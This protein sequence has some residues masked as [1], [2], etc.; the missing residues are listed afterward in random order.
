[1]CRSAFIALVAVT[2]PATAQ[3]PQKFEEFDKAIAG[4][5]V[6]E[7]LFKL[8]QKDEHVLAEIQ[9]SQLDRPFLCTMSL[10]RGG[11]DQAGHT[12]NGDEQWVIAFKR[13]GDKIHLVRKNV[14]F[15]AGGPLARAM[16]TTYTDSVL[17][18][19]RIKSV[20]P[21]KQSVLIDLNDVFFSNFA[22]LP[23]GLLDGN[24]TAWHKVK[25]FPKNVELQ[26]AATFANGPADD[27]VI[28][29]RG[30]TVNIHYGI[31]ELPETGYTPRH[32]DD[33]VGYFLTAL[34][35][36]GSDSKDTAFVRYVN[37][38][39]LERADNSTWKEGAKLVPPKKKIV[40][41]IEKSVPD[42]FRAAVRE[43]ILEW[44]KAFEKV[45][46]RDAIEVRQQ[47]G[48]DFDPEDVTYST[49]RWITTDIGYAMGPSRA[50]PFTGEIVDADIIFDASMVRYYRR[51]QQLY[52]TSEGVTAEPASPIQAAR[53]GWMIP[54]GAGRMA[55]SWNDKGD[56]PYAAQ[57]AQFRAFRAGLCQCASHKQTE[58]GL[59]LAAMATRYDLKPGDKLSDEMVQQAVKETVMHE[60]GHTLGLRHN[61]K[62]STMLKNEQ[63]HDLGVTRKQG[64]VGSVMDYN[65][66]N[67]APKGVK[68]GDYFTSTL[69]P[70]DYWAIEY[71]YKPLP[72]GTDGEREELGKIAAR[73][74][75]PGLDFGTD[76]DLMSPDPHINMWDLGSDPMKF[77]LDRMALAEELMKGLA[78]RVV[79][80]GEGYQ[81]ARIAFGVMLQQYGNAAFLTAQY[82]GAEHVNRDHKGDANARDPFVPVSPARQREAL[83]F[84]QDR[85]LTDKPFNFPPDV[86]R[87]LAAD[88]WLHWG[89]EMAFFAGTNFPLNDRILGI[90]RVCL[91]ELL[92]DRTLSRLQDL[93]AKG[94]PAQAVQVAEILRALTDSTFADLPTGD[95][96]AA[97][98]SSVLRRNLQRAYLAEL[99]RLV[100]KGT[101]AD[102]RSLARMHLRD[103]N[104]RIDK[105][106]NDP[107]AQTD[108]TLRGSNRRRITTP[109]RPIPPGRTTA[110][111]PPRSPP[112]REH[113]PSRTPARTAGTPPPGRRSPRPRG[114]PTAPRTSAAAPARRPGTYTPSARRRRRAGA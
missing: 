34:K 88:R 20:H 78:D 57:R 27:S 58:L 112:R 80:K 40:F 54:Q 95:K 87:K 11:M 77:A 114:R 8:Y 61:F 49:F 4:A 47:E 60:V 2:V 46:F 113:S 21:I 90:Q 3:P 92:N 32:A 6:T 39:R 73:S 29:R 31:V 111:S 63:L 85:I 45:G 104:K 44:N 100:L 62:A 84:L 50:N 103:V 69:G 66:A 15:K 53:R 82:V 10:A 30:N 109:R 55:G 89:N 24:R 33:R 51:D 48:E 93:G 37:R 19:L 79:E 96:A 68:Q 16:E 72:G 41:W 107:K 81:R 25:A 108:D 9:P 28:D 71:G 86:L 98:K 12:L 102:A 14:R 83:K 76:E 1:M 97:E 106:L 101:V 42:E 75:A 13:V 35:D 38:W 70:Y 22:D 26:V 56:D 17:M 110:G 65:P 7:G 64:L 105:L 74:A 99:S 94:D 59:A 91:R 67:L 43:G 36:F 52:K 23:F 18:A 5:K